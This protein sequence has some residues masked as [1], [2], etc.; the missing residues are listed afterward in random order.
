MDRKALA[1]SKRDRDSGIDEV[2]ED[3]S[4]RARQKL[5]EEDNEIGRGVDD[6]AI[7]LPRDNEVELPREAPSAIDD[8]QV[9]LPA[10]NSMIATSEGQAMCQSSPGSRLGC[11]GCQGVL[12]MHRMSEV[13]T[14]SQ[15]VDSIAAQAFAT[16][17]IRLRHHRLCRLGR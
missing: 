6:E 1:G 8:H 2:T 12:E 15:A 13:V 3:E 10:D 4:R 7:F 5:D 9:F 17:R 16:R 14:G 11:S